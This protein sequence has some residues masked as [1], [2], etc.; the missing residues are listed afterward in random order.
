MAP[1]VTL[2]KALM[3]KEHVIPAFPVFHLLVPGA[4]REKFLSETD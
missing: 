1:H 4:F 2:R 3:H